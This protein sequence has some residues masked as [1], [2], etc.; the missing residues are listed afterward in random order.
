MR[1]AHV[2]S[3]L[4]LAGLASC[5]RGGRTGGLPA[6]PE[7]PLAA[8]AAQRL[9]LTPV[10]FVRGAD[11]LGWVQ[12]LGGSRAAGRKLDTS[13]VAAL[14]ARGL[15][16]RWVLPTELVHAF[17]RNRSYATDPYQLALEP[18]RSPKFVTAERYGEPLSSQLRTLIALQQDARFVLVPIELRFERDGAAAR[19]VLKVALMD[20]RFAHANWVGDVKGVPATTAPQA[21][22]SVAASV[23]DLFVAP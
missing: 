3:A 7:R 14:D 23:A 6:E 16:Q 21:M 18:V 19:G 15:A 20:P 13:L 12:Q 8:Y 9:V 17:E 5:G 10:G 1:T 11:S 2:W 4:L 22:A